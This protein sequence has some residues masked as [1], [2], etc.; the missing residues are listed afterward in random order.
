MLYI[1]FILFVFLLMGAVIIGIGVG[2]G[3]FLSKII[4][5]LGIEF[6][7][8][9]GA[10]F[11]IGIIHFFIKLMSTLLNYEEE[12]EYDDIEFEEPPIILPPKILKSSGSKRNKK[13]KK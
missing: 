10:I 1:I 11:S 7:I 2:I 9:A 6:A 8:V 4:P 5:N 12:L 13:R 3:F